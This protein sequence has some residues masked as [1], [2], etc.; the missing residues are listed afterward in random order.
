MLYDMTCESLRIRYGF[1]TYQL[2][3]MLYSL[4]A[5]F[6]LQFAKSLMTPRKS[7]IMVF[8]TSKAESAHVINYLVFL[9]ASTTHWI[10]AANLA[11][12][13]ESAHVINYLALRIGLQPNR[14][15]IIITL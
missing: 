4:V 3:N 10:R 7:L 12:K 6:G 11:L 8:K 13:A 14:H 9:G 5:D 15:A 1:V 2:R